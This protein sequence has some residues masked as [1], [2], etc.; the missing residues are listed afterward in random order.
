VVAS[1][2]LQ[3]PQ[4]VEASLMPIN[5]GMT[6]PSV[7]FKSEKSALLW[8]TWPLRAM[9][10]RSALRRTVW[11]RTMGPLQELAP[12]VGWRHNF[13]AYSFRAFAAW[14]QGD[15]GVWCSR[16]RWQRLYFC[17]EPHQQG[18]FL[19]RPLTVSQL[20]LRSDAS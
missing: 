6:R 12:A 15:G 2:F 18:R 16:P 19:L 17:P 5:L 3:N 13:V 10:F 9:A 4:K 14:S 20:S 11:A 7:L 8:Y 1:C